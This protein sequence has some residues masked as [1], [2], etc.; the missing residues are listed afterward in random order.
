MKKILSI[1]LVISVSFIMV[2]FSGCKDNKTE[3]IS[4]ATTE[5][6]ENTQNQSDNGF[7][8]GNTKT[9]E[10]YDYEDGTY[11]I[12]GY[13]G[14][15]KIV[16]IPSEINGIKVTGLTGNSFYMNNTIEEVIIPD[17]IITIS[18]NAFSECKN[19][20]K[21]SFPETLQYIGEMAFA[22]CESLTE[23]VLPKDLEYLGVNAFS[24]CRSLSSLTF[25]CTNLTSIPEKCFAHTA[26]KVIEIPNTVTFIDD[27]FTGIK[28]L[29]KAYIPESVTEM[30]CS[31]MDSPNVVIY[32]AHGSCAYYYAQDEN[33]QFVAQ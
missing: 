28:S 18:S 19:L 33:H 26:L 15:D 1:L 9:W 3:I 6:V 17:T 12:S 11:F 22:Y 14:T 5:T 31:F 24:M 21:V 23:V 20:K 13:N 2:T 25:E 27:S 4:N 7:N 30:D 29:E 16:K 8:N 32:G 10:V